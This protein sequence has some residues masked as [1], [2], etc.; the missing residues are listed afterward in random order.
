[1]KYNWRQTQFRDTNVL[2]PNQTVLKWKHLAQNK[3][4]AIVFTGRT[5]RRGPA[6]HI[7]RVKKPQP[8]VAQSKPPI[9]AP[10]QP[11]AVAPVELHVAVA[12]PAMRQNIL[13]Q[14]AMGQNLL[15]QLA[16]GHNFLPQQAAGQNFL[17]QPAAVN[18]ILHQAAMTHNL[19]PQTAFA[20]NI[21][22]QPAAEQN[23]LHQP[24]AEKKEEPQPVNPWL[25]SNATD[26]KINNNN[27]RQ[28]LTDCQELVKPQV[29]MTKPAAVKEVLPSPTVSTKIATTKT[30][31]NKKGRNKL[32]GNVVV[33]GNSWD[34]I[35]AP[36][37]K[38][39]PEK[40]QLAVAKKE[41]QVVSTREQKVTDAQTVKNI[42][43]LS[44]P[45]MTQKMLPQLAAEKKVPL[46]PTVQTKIVTTKTNQNKGKKKL[47]SNVVV[48]GNSCSTA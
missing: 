35:H 38:V 24:V 27:Q 30:N 28:N 36:Q 34:T 43:T 20:H 3:T 41:T 9:L 7:A 6:A 29:P 10:K 2:P 32:K 26:S 42:K 45:A 22:P 40:A 5:W 17:L 15:P 23:F 47:K 33:I 1:M 19:L 37:P 16:A 48:I 12:Q 14:P 25:K 31:Q 4:N 39:A 8:D 46:S 44:Q 11:R 21:V 13:P 18:W